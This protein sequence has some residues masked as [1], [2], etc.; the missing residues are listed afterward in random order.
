MDR[1]VY[2]GDSP[3]NLTDPSG[4]FDTGA[5]I[6]CTG[7]ISLLGLAVVVGVFGAPVLPA[8]APAVAFLAFGFFDGLGIATSPEGILYF[9]G[10]LF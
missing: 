7:A 4:R 2:V 3:V 8:T 9:C 10:R 1:Y 6:V 5:Y